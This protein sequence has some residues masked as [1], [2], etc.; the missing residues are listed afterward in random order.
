MLESR[1]Y[2]IEAV[3]AVSMAF[4]EKVSY[5][6]SLDNFIAHHVNN[7]KITVFNRSAIYHCAFNEG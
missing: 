4:K 3:K 7:G 1:Y 2:Q 5:R 6:I